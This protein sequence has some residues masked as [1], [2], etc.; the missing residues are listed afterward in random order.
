MGTCARG[1]RATESVPRALQY[2]SQALDRC[3]VQLQ[4]VGDD[5]LEGQLAIDFQDSTRSLQTGNLEYP[6]PSLEGFL[7]G[8]LCLSGMY[9]TDVIDDNLAPEGA[10]P[11]WLYVGRGLP[12]TGH[13]NSCRVSGPEKTTW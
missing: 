10:V 6:R 12:F 1:S 7:P 4:G 5:S 8:D 2:P 13:R 11:A 3:R 9:S